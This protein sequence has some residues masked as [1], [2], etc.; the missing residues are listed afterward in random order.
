MRIRKSKMSE[1]YTIPFI[2]GKKAKIKLQLLC[3]A[4]RSCNG[5]QCI[6]SCTKNEL[7]QQ[8][9]KATKSS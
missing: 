8:N 3:I 4:Y 9:K 5:D 2:E 7:H 1:Y 6:K